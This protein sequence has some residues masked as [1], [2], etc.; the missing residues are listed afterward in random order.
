VLT[1]APQTFACWNSTTERMN[2][3]LLRLRFL[4]GV[5]I[6]YLQFRLKSKNAMFVVRTAIASGP[7]VNVLGGVLT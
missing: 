2:P 5:D 3:R 7:M 1:A 4:P 6:P